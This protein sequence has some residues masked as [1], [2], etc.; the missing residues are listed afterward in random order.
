MTAEASRRDLVKAVQK[1]GYELTE[2]AS[3]GVYQILQYGPLFSLQTRIN[4][5]IVGVKVK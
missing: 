1:A 4:E 5:I 3:Q 2:E